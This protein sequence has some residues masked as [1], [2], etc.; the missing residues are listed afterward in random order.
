M[1]IVKIKIDELTPYAEKA[2]A[3][4]VDTNIWELSER[5]REIV[6]SLGK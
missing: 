6:K 3:E 4:K 5:E 2:A 1:K